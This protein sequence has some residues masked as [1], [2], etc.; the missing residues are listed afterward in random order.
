MFMSRHLYRRGVAER[1]RRGMGIARSNPPVEPVP[2]PPELDNFVGKWVAIKEG[3][4][5]AAADSSR[6]LVDEVHK[7]GEHGLGAVVQFVAP[8]STSF[9]VGV[10]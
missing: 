1:Y 7:L 5:V 2:R 8:P 6:A 3:R 4:V 10:G 9:M